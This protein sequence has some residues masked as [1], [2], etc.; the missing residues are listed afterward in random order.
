[1]AIDCSKVKSSP[2]PNVTELE[3]C[4]VLTAPLTLELEVA[5]QLL[6]KVIKDVP[7]E[8]RPAALAAALATIAAGEKAAETLVARFPTVPHQLSNQVI[9]EQTKLMQQYV[10]KHALT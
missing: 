4:E 2:D 10:E 6:V 8:G 9:E 3:S 5:A 7:P 1:M